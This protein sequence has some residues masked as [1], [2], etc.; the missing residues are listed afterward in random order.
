MGGFNPTNLSTSAAATFA[1][2]V[3]LPADSHSRQQRALLTLLTVQVVHTAALKRYKQGFQKVRQTKLMCPD[4]FL[5]SFQKMMYPGGGHS[6]G[7][8]I[9]A[10]AAAMTG[11][12]H[13]FTSTCVF[14]KGDKKC[15]VRTI[16]T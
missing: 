12:K 8:R 4:F 14:P 9:F 10:S 5:A 15:I 2:L 6:Q 16:D 11:C 1:G 7:L 13:S 3:T